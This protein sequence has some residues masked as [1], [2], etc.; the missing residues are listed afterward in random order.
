MDVVVARD[1][2][3][4]LL[5]SSSPQ[6]FAQGREMVPWMWELSSHM[7]AGIKLS[8][9]SSSVWGDNCTFVSLSSC[10]WVKRHINMVALPFVFC[11]HL[12]CVEALACYFV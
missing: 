4:G 6:W 2:D 5:G 1:S 8:V 3:P 12:C 7:S 9:F 11:V 10:N